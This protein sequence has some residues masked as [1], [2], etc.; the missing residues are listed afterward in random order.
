[1]LSGGLRQSKC[2]PGFPTPPGNKRFHPENVSRLW[3]RHL[4]ALQ[5]VFK[6]IRS[7]EQERAELKAPAGEMHDREP[8]QEIQ[9]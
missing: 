7:V 5:R 4:G 8:D 3:L 9:F 2:L 1:M 6:D